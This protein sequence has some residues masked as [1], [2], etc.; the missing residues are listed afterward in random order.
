MAAINA[1]RRRQSGLATSMLSEGLSKGPRDE[2]DTRD[3][4]ENE[5]LGGVSLLKWSYRPC[6]FL[7]L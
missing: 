2:I 3:D 7:E 5:I 4:E 6:S 1:D